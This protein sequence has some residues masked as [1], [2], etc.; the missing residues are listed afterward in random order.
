MIHPQHPGKANLDNVNQ[1]L[2][3]ICRR[4]DSAKVLVCPTLP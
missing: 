1:D 4:I 2:E 3:A